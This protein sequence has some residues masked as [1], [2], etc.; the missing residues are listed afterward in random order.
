MRDPFSIL[1]LDETAGKK[2]IIAR[3][4]EA[5]RDGLHD[6]KTIAAAQKTLFNPSART[7]ATLCY[8]VDFTPY[9]VDAPE[10]PG[11]ETD[12]PKLTRLVL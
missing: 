9:A 12:C 11:P 3:V 4:A 2:E 7:R 1:D 6:A 8:R 10:A 5:L